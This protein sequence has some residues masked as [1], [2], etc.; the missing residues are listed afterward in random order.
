MNNLKSK[1]SDAIRFAFNAIAIAWLAS[2]TMTACYSKPL[3]GLQSEN[4]NSVDGRRWTLEEIDGKP[5]AA[6]TSRD[7]MGTQGK[8]FIEIGLAKGVFSGMA[9]CNLIT[10]K[11]ESD[12]NAIKFKWETS[13]ALGCK[14]HLME[15]ERAFIDLLQKAARYELLDDT[16][17]LYADGRIVL[18]FVGAQKDASGEN[19]K[20]AGTLLKTDVIVE[21]GC[22]AALF[23]NQ[24]R[25]NESQNKADVG[26][27]TQ[28]WILSEIAGQTLPK[29]G[30]IPFVTF[31]KS[32]WGVSGNS[33]CNAFSGG[34]KTGAD[35]INLDVFGRPLSP[36]NHC[37][38]ES[39]IIQR[40]FI[41]ALLKVNRFEIKDR[42]LNLYE[43]DK[44]LLTFASS[45]NKRI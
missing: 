20:L 44:L 9:S 25:A 26:L 37:N 18:K 30:S 16:L 35:K 29:A 17:L 7:G 10:G 27:E 6:K 12:S 19:Q 5:A 42:K 24:K 41:Y 39:I 34:Y 2:A 33:G 14:D 43:D 36:L 32:T 4:L 8:P 38:E 11:V 23:N 15:Q 1:L 28:K 3:S 45:D 31:D 22:A 21:S 40:N 13:T